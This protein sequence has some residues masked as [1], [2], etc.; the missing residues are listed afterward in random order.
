M[1]R[2]SWRKREL[3]AEPGA[4]FTLI[5]F[6]EGSGIG[7]RQRISGDSVRIFKNQGKVRFESEI[8]ADEDSSEGVR[9]LSIE[10]FTIG[11]MIAG[12]AADAGSAGFIA[13]TDGANGERVHEAG[14]L[15]AG[16]KVPSG[17]GARRR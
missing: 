17:I 12:F 4:P 14:W 10:G 7:R 3:S 1:G 2:F 15:K 16:R 13:G 11:A 5:S 6:V 8:R 9:V